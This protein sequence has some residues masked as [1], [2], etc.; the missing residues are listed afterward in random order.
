MSEARDKPILCLDFDG[1]VHS[2]E[3]GW[4]DGAI[5][6]TLTPGFVPW[7][8]N[9]L[10]H[11]KLVIY[12]SRSATLEGREAMRAWLTSQLNGSLLSVFDVSLAHEKPP[13]WLTI[14]DRCITFRGSWEQ[15]RPEVLRDFKPWNAPP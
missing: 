15:L 14:D 1:V 8:L 11:F 5:C 13:A 12:S 9:A 6:G 3:R 7:A 10:S 4:Q 2:Y